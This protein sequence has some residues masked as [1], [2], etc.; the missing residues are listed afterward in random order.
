MTYRTPQEAGLSPIP[1]AP[2]RSR[3]SVKPPKHQRYVVRLK[4]GESVS[5]LLA[6][7]ASPL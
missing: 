5:S 3:Y 6:P 4:K 2:K 1:P 7:R